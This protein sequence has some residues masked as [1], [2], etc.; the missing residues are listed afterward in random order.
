MPVAGSNARIAATLAGSGMKGGDHVRTTPPARTVT[1]PEDPAA[2]F[3]GPESGRPLGGRGSGGSDLRVIDAAAPGCP[4]RGSVPHPHEP[5]TSQ[6]DWRRLGCRRR[7]R[8]RRP[9]ADRAHGRRDVQGRDG[10]PPGHRHAVVR[11]AARDGYESA[12][13]LEAGF[14]AWIEA[15]NNVANGEVQVPCRL[16]IHAAGAG[17]PAVDHR[18]V[19]GLLG[20]PDALGRARAGRVRSASVASGTSGA[21]STMAQIAV[22]RGVPADAQRGRSAAPCCSRRTSP[23][24]ASSATTARGVAAAQGVRAHDPRRLRDVAVYTTAGGP[25]GA[26]AWTCPWTARRVAAGGPGSEP[27]AP[28]VTV[29][30]LGPG[31]SRGRA[32]RAARPGADP[33]TGSIP[34]HGSDRPC[35]GPGSARAVR[36]LPRPAGA[37][38]RASP[39]HVGPVGG[40]GHRQEA[41]GDALKAWRRLSSPSARGG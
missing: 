35:A 26:T 29:V 37:V 16:H 36:L 5:V 20:A 17:A 15:G 40:I 21:R 28:R 27:Q 25:S 23:A 12:R 22:S 6:V 1:P 4:H 31:R 24:V 34:A 3:A 41:A 14:P 7:R 2:G 9:A 13:I 30:G 39:E 19:R 32:A 11:G 38:W 18:H 33:A 10:R 8:R